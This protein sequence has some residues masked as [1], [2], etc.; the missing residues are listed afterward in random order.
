MM[1]SMSDK[2]VEGGAQ[3]GILSMV[4]GV[5]AVT[6]RCFE[7]ARGSGSSVLQR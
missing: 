7:A 3:P 2:V 6:R 4:K 1:G 5:E